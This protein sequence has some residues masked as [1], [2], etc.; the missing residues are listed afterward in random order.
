MSEVM[1]C[2]VLRVKPDR[3]DDV[4]KILGGLM[5]ATHQEDGCERYAFF[6]V[7]GDPTKYVFVERWRDQAA[8][9]GHLA[10]AQFGELTEFVAEPA[11]IMQLEALG[12]GDPAKGSL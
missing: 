6:R 11:Q 5:R 8:V 2:G 9:D 1:I 12:E 10:S 4:E 3:Q 7:K